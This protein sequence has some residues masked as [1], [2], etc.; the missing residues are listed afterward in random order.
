MHTFKFWHLSRDLSTRQRTMD[1]CL[2]KM[3]SGLCARSSSVRVVCQ[4]WVEH[5][6]V[7]ADTGRLL[8]T[9]L[10]ALLGKDSYISFL[11]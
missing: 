3:M 5:A 2:L 8:E 6:L 11:L 9:L 1:L 10:L 4:V 7:R